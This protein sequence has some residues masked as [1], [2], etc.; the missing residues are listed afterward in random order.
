LA[1]AVHRDH[2]RGPEDDYNQWSGTPPVLPESAEA[3][4]AFEAGPK[5]AEQ[6]EP[7]TQH[8]A[9]ALHP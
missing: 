4:T 5:D 2:A 8:E 3:M 9:E 6:Y 7:G 1:K